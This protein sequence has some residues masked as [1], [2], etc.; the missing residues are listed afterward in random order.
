MTEENT[1][2][3]IKDAVNS[4]AFSNIVSPPTKVVGN[5]FGDLFNFA[6]G[7]N[8]HEK[9]E[10]S[11]LKHQK[12][13]EDFQ[14][15]L[16][17]NVSSIPEE[18]RIPP[19][20]SVVGP[21]LE[22][23][24]YYFD[25]DEIRE[26][27]EKLITNSMD[28]RQAAKVHPSFTE[29]IKQM[30]PLDAQNLKLF[31]TN[32]QLPIVQFKVKSRNDIRKYILIATNVFISNPD[33]QD[34]ELQ[35]VSISSLC[36]IGLLEIKYGDYITNDSVYE[37]FLSLPLYI[38]LKNQLEALN[39]ASETFIGITN[40]EKHDLHCEKGYVQ[41]T[42]LGKTFISICLDPLPKKSNP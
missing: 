38:D 20:E 32:S 35:A 37:Q 41:L 26:M 1:N 34:I 16:N 28:D 33:C 36:R 8:M 14:K 10:K 7:Y 40:K 23:S 27:F 15:K 5:F 9:A 31:K 17:E 19:K 25:E 4:E 42:P 22:A 30:S 18:H 3:K 13:I 29:I 6:F 24:K 21:A 12:N 2:D 11:R 39:I